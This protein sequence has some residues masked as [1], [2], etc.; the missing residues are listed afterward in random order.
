MKKRLFTSVMAAVM[1]ISTLAGSVFAEPSQ[2]I[3]A[4]EDANIS[5]P[6]EAAPL[7]ITEPEIT[8]AEC[9]ILYNIEND[10]ILFEYNSS[11]R[12]YPA[13]T[14]KLMTAIVIF[15]Y[16]KD[17]LDTKITVTQSM[18]D[19]SVGNR[20]GFNPGEIVTVEQMLNCMLINSAN[21]A[22]IILA[23]ACA[24]TTEAFVEMMNEKAAWIGAYETHYTNPTGL[25]SELMFTTARDTVKIARCAYDI[26]GFV[27]ITSTPKYVMEGTNASDYRNVYNRNCMISKFYSVD[28]FYDK[29]LG[30]NAGATTQGGYAMCGLAEDPEAGLS[31]IAI[32]LGC[33]YD[34]DTFYNYVNVRNMFDWAFETY[35]YTSVLSSKKTICEIDV[36]LSSAID[37]VTLVPEKDISVYLPTAIIP[38]RDLHYSF[39]T[40]EDAI[41]APVEKG[42]KAGAITV[43]YGDE[44]LGSCSLVTTASVTR[45]EFLYFLSRVQELTE[46]RFFRAAAI[47]AVILT[48]LYISGSAYL[49]ERRMRR[50]RY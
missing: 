18:I 32:A 25:H 39:N 13:S 36:R 9:A 33:G 29:A 50:R 15:E 5:V 45:S 26:P 34:D 14:A 31:Y 22:A 41:D 7:A 48:I 47:S 27:D 17:A 2:G 12:V 40:F 16:Y 1:A 10:R 4:S 11:D 8:D 30:M 24:G 38:D 46:S 20:I 3:G 44:I 19:E 23:H 35:G 37:Y 49:R 42:Q 6:D 28:Y 43:M 21:D